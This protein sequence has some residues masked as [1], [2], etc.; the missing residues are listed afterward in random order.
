MRI[1]VGDVIG[2]TFRLTDLLG[3]G[4]MGYVFLAENLLVHV[5]V[6]VKVLYLYQGADNDHERRFQ[7]EARAAMLLN[8]PN[9]VRVQVFGYH[10]DAAYI[11]MEYVPGKSLDEWIELHESLPTLEEVACVMSQLFSA[12]NAA[13]T[14]GIVHRDIKPANVLI[15]TDP[16]SSMPIAKVV[17]FGLAH[18]E[19]K[20]DA[21]PTLTLQ[22]VIAGTPA[23]MSPEQCRS[24]AVGPSTDLYAAG[25]V[26]TT[27]LQGSPPFEAESPMDLMAKQM[28]LPP[29]P[30]KRPPDAEPVPALLERLRLDLMAK[31]VHGR[32]E[33]AAVAAERL[34]EAMSEAENDSRYPNRRGHGSLGPRESRR[35]RTD[36]P[37]SGPPPVAVGS[38]AS[39][40]V[41]VLKK[42][43]DGWSESNR[44]GMAVHGIS[45]LSVS[46][47]LG[48]DKVRG[49]ILVL[50]AADDVDGALDTLR[51][52][53]EMPVIVCVSRLDHDDLNRL[54]EAGASEVLLY[55]ISPDTLAKRIRRVGKRR[56]T[57]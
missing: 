14:I 34:R 33:S 36:S 15:M 44:T 4:G 50:D 56:R 31:Q 13:H 20:L 17:D 46:D 8:H 28:F 55:P 10:E 3:A 11:V 45:V 30:L 43:A 26:L 19:D 24:L 2:G 35:P 53:E 25:C 47:H 39:I 1:H 40:S 27:L 16:A 23:Y 38:L 7:R 5:Q 48:S 32:P 12:L 6:A 29:E 9:I 52:R 22:D 18:V 49:E 41:V 57:L 37:G 54:I 51:S 42:H 21:G